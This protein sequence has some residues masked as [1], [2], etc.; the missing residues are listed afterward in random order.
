VIKR[1]IGI[2]LLVAAAGFILIQ[3]VPYGRNHQNPP[4][5]QEPAWDKPETRTLTQRACFDCHSNQTTWP[6]YSNVA[7]V[8]WLIQHDVEEGRRRLNFSAWGQGEQELNEVGEIIQE[9]EMPPLYFVALHQSAKLSSQEQSALINGLYATV[10]AARG[11]GRSEAGE[12][13]D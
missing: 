1:V 13:N 4:V 2:L 3:L 6:W 8:S 9:G 11:E 12:G 7:P 5:I 10:G